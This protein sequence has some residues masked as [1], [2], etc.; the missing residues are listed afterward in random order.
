MPRKNY[1]R[2]QPVQKNR[3]PL[4]TVHELNNCHQKRRF[5]TQQQAEREIASRQLT[6][7]QLLLATYKCHWCGGWH[8][9]S[10]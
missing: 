2:S 3:Q 9:T 1:P 6:D 8:L 7:P 4:T 10:R 5:S